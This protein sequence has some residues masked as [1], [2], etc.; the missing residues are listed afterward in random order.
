MEIILTQNILFYVAILF[1]AFYNLMAISD[2]VFYKFGLNNYNFINFIIK[3]MGFIHTIFICNLCYNFRT[4]RIE[5]E[6]FIENLDITKAYFVY[7]IIVMT[8]YHTYIREYEKLLIHHIILLIGLYSDKIALYPE[9]VAQGFFA[10]VTNLPLMLGW[11]LLK[12]HQSNTTLFFT[13]GILLLLC[14]LFYRVINFTDLFLKSL[15]ITDK[16]H[17][18]LFIFII[19]IINI[20]WFGKLMDKFFKTLL[21]RS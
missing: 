5:K 3:L 8:Y 21:G 7:D 2:V 4:G 17:E 18:I 14:F 6:V 10:E 13:N 1:T 19:M 9:L 15:N 11:V 20:F 16:Y 12:T